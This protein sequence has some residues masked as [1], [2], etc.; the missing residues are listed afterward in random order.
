M[1]KGGKETKVFG[2][3]GKE[4]GLGKDE[5]RNITGMGGMNCRLQNLDFIP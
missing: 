4:P 2:V 1:L 5:A 3:I